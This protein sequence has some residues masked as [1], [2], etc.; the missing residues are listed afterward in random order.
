MKTVVIKNNVLSL[1]FVCLFAYSSSVF[2]QSG[3]GSV[4][5]VRVDVGHGALH[6]PF[7]SPKLETKYKELAGINN[8]FMD[9]QSSYTTFTLPSNTTV[10]AQQLIDIGVAVGYPAADF[11]VKFDTQPITQSTAH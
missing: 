11:T 7:L 4:K 5:Y 2:A 8:F 9:R 1:L 10:T 3:S 6:C